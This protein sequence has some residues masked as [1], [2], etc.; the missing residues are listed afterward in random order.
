MKGSLIP[1]RSFQKIFLGM[2]TNASPKRLHTGH[3]LCR[4]SHEWKKT[5]RRAGRWIDFDNDYKTLNLEFMETV[6][7]VFSQISKQDLVYRGMKVVF[8]LALQPGN[9]ICCFENHAKTGDSLQTH[10][11]SIAYRY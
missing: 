2:Y 5:V 10:T 8:A 9:C 1:I 4:Y 7:W 3:D 11:D 6:W